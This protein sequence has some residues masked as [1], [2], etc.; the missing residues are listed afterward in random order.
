MYRRLI[1]AAAV[2]ALV[3]VPPRFVRAQDPDTATRSRGVFLG[4]IAEP[5]PE[6]AQHK[7]AMVREVTPNSPAAKAG[8]RRGDIITKVDNRDVQDFEDLLN[9]LSQHKPGD[10]VNI[11]MMRNGQDKQLTVTLTRRPSQRF[12]EDSENRRFEGEERGAPGYYGRRRPT[13]FLGVQT[14]ELTPD[15]RSQQGISARE[16]AVV[17]E[18]MPNTPAEE[19]GLQEGDVITKVNDQQ[20]STPEDLRRAIQEAGPGHEV[21]MDVMRGRRHREVTAHL[22][23][24][25]AEFGQRY[26]FTDGSQSREIQRLQQQIQQLERR[27]RKLEQNMQ[28]Q[29]SR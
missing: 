14:E 18:V 10:K 13:A 2:C 17:V 12:T 21:T 4:I 23:E 15:V 26:G 29:S 1:I 7:G 27:L 5:A 9:A 22:D 8:L 11:H 19:A 6:D 28:N 24:G 3:M 20:I 25:S 16:G